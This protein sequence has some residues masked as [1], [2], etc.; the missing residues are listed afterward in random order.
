MKLIGKNKKVGD[1]IHLVDGKGT[2]YIAELLELRKKEAQLKILSSEPQSPSP[3]S[4]HIAIAPTKNIARLEWFLEKATEIGIQEITP[5][6]FRLFIPHLKLLRHFPFR[7]VI[8][9]EF[10]GHAFGI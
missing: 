5:I 8:V 3:F 7:R 6:Y 9:V 4:L 10:S 1:Q 2:F